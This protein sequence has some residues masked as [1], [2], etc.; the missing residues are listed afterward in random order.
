MCIRDRSAL[1]TSDTTDKPS[2]NQE[3]QNREAHAKPSGTQYKVLLSN[4]PPRIGHYT[5]M[6]PEFDLKWMLQDEYGPVLSVHMKRSSTPAGE[7][8]L[9]TAEVAFANKKTLQKVIRA[10]SER[11]LFLFG[12]NLY[13]RAF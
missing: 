12:R 4:I 2:E 3:D 8:L 7:C 6:G 10:S 11:F 1:C 5:R 13:A 9:G